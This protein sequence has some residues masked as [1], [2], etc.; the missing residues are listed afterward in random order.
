MYGKN[1]K[2]DF[3]KMLEKVAAL[4]FRNNILQKENNGLSEQIN[5]LE[6]KLKEKDMKLDII[7][8]YYSSLVTHWTCFTLLNSLCYINLPF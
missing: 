2:P 5:N 3:H 8:E 7:E 6:E 4:A 1:C